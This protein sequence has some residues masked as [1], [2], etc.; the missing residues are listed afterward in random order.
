MLP[1]AENGSRVAASTLKDAAAGATTRW[2]A[3]RVEWKGACAR[4]LSLWAWSQ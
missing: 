3:P 4:H 2:F 1:A